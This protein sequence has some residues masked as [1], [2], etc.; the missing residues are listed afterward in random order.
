MGLVILS[1]GL[2]AIAAMQ[3]T[4]VKGN[5]FSH[6]LMQASYTA[7]ERLESL[8]LLPLESA[9]LQPGEHN[10]GTVTVGDI[11][12][13]RSYAVSVNG[14]Q[15]TILYTVRWNDG[16]NHVITFSTIRAQ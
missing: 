1:I 8:N 16:L 6:S 13:N 11:V 5:F 9:A 3:T 15:V 7:Q 4:S 12:F 10:D 2:L 14:G